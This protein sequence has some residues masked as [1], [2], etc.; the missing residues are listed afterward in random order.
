MISVLILLLFFVFVHCQPIQQKR[1]FKVAIQKEY[2]PSNHNS[3]VV[4]F[5]AK[6]KQVAY[7]HGSGYYGEISIGTPPQKF[8]VVFDTGSSDLWVVS[9]DC[10]VQACNNR[11]KFDYQA[12]QSYQQDDSDSEDNMIEVIYGTGSIQGHLGK[13]MVRLANEQIQI[14]DQIMANA[15]SI[16]HDFHG[17]PFHGIFGLG[18]KGLVQ[19][20]LFAI[21]SQ[22]NAGEIDFGGIDRNRYEGELNYVDA[23]DS[24]Y[25]MMAMDKVQ[26]GSDHTFDDRKGIID[27]GSTL[28]IMPQKDAKEY[29]KKVK[30]AFSNGD[31]TWSLPCRYVDQLQPLVIH[32]NNIHCLSGISEQDIEE[33]DTW[34]LGDVFLKS[35]YTVFDLGNKKIGFATAKDDDTMQDAAYKRILGLE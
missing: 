20:P 7:N 18:L 33:T 25:W 34:I 27:S 28:I 1:H 19:E 3:S 35:F 21:Y 13:D 23:I 32:P 11:Q 16:S 6:Q 14:Q 8:N 29:H 4:S 10:R 5:L 2:Y 22:H 30:G 24:S 31:G 12:S 15:L 9:S 26:L 17:L